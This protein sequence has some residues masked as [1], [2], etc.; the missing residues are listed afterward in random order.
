MSCSASANLS[1]DMLRSTLHS[2][3]SYAPSFG[4]F[5]PRCSEEQGS[6]LAISA[7]QSILT[8]AAQRRH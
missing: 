1:Q 2:S 3:E 7:K 6:V 4:R 8:K 5:L